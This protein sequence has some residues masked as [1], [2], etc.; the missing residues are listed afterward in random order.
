M[1]GER[2]FFIDK[3]LILNDARMKFVN[4]AIMSDKKSDNFSFNV[5]SPERVPTEEQL[6]ATAAFL[7]RHLDSY[8]DPLP[9]IKKAIGY[10]TDP[11]RGGVVTELLDGDKIIG[12]VVIN[13]TKMS[14]YIPENILVYIAMDRS[15]RGQGLGKKL[16][17]KAISLVK[18][19]IALHV[20]PDNPARFLYEK[21]GFTSKYKEMRLQR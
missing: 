9:A 20:E 12:A 16:M 17:E 4:F 2:V 7:H 14:E 8:G 10:A 18:G 15:Y 21:L 6:E 11:Q 19:G 3:C 5:Y 1:H 13:D